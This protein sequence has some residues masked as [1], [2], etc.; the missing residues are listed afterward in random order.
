MQVPIYDIQS[1]LLDSVGRLYQR[2]V[3]L[4]VLD[5]S[6]LCFLHAKKDQFSL[7]RHFLSGISTAI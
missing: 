3:A 2:L 6:L 1:N 4:L 5:N 7:M